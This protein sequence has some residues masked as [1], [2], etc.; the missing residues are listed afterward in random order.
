M[1][2]HK[3]VS[4][5]SLIFPYVVDLV[6]PFVAYLVVRWLGAPG[7]WALT[8]GGCVAAF[9]TTV[10][11]IRRKGLD[12][13]G[14]LVLLELALSVVLL[15]AV[16]DNRLLLIRPSFYTALASLYFL[17]TLAGE[18]PVTF[19]GARMVAAQGDPVREA[20][21]DQLWEQSA[22]FRRIHRLMTVG[23]ALALFADSALRVVIV[24]TFPFERAAWLGN[25]P[26]VA[27]VVLFIAASA[28][29]GR[30]FRRLAQEQM[31]GAIASHV[32]PPRVTS[33]STIR[34]G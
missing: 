14:V 22:E 10:N 15:V 29:A 6:G 24:Y 11:T 33:A 19:D 34:R 7:L 12:R 28:L 3:A 17:S 2:T 20:A 13:V 4:K 25:V 26:H 23:L 27:A 30:R 18:R 5:R 8:A 32:V 16:R 9:S 1:A 21:F 31:G